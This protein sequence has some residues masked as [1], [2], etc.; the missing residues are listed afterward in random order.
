MS[1]S[2]KSRH[3]G[4]NYLGVSDRVKQRK[5]SAKHCPTNKMLADLFSNPLQGSKFKFSRRVVMVWDDV[6]TFWD[7]SNYKDEL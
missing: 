4:I 7:Y 1:C 5:I 3:I 6:A 2:S